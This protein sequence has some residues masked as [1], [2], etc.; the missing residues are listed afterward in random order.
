MEIRYL[1]FLKHDKPN[2]RVFSVKIDGNAFLVRVRLSYYVGCVYRACYH[3]VLMD[4]EGNK[5]SLGKD[6]TWKDTRLRLL[7]LMVEKDISMSPTIARTK[8]HGI[9]KAKRNTK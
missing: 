1:K 9:S 6:L 3:V 5:I 7:N 4:T 2:T 8:N